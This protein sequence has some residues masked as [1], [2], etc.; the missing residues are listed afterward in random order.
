MFLSRN[1]KNNVYSCKSQFYCIKV[2]Y[3]VGGGGGGGG[4][5]KIYRYVFVMSEDLQ[6]KC[7]SCI[8]LNLTN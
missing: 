4:A 2:G 1:K 5:V 7:T 8:R 6:T 3:T